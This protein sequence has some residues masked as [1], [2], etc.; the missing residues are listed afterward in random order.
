MGE[1]KR[2]KYGL[3]AVELT[4]LPLCRI[5]ASV[6]WVSI[7]S[8]N[9]LSPVRRQAIT[10]T[11]AGLLSI[12][13][14][15]TNFSEIWM[16]ILSFSFKKMHLKMSSARMVAILSRGRLVKFL[17]HP[18]IDGIPQPYAGLSTARV[19]SIKLPHWRGIHATGTCSR[20]LNIRAIYICNHSQSACFT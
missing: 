15:A 10:R 4:H 2:K 5:Y 3:L 1:C 13:L 7:G 11:N 16:G 20:L 8:G 12:G 14:M 17:F 9:G 6:N 19:T 18:P